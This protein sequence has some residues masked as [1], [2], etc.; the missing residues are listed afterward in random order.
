M[1]EP[2]TMSMLSRLLLVVVVRLHLLIMFPP[3][4]TILKPSLRLRSMRLYGID[5]LAEPISDDSAE[6]ADRRD[7]FV[8]ARGVG[9]G[10][11]SDARDVHMAPGLDQVKCDGVDV[12]AFEV[13]DGEFKAGEGDNQRPNA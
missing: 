6:P 7:I 1:S 2:A 3:C 5:H 9:V 8:C 4:T 11:T 13:Q 10:E 12:V